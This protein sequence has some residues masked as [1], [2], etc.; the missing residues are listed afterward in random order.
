MEFLGHVVSN[1]GVSADSHKIKAIPKW[2]RPKNPME[3][4]S[5]LGL[6]GYYRR[7]IQNISKIPTPVTN[8]TKKVIKHE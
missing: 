2:P 6:A 4:R 7:F 1:E 5:L 3:V 8:L